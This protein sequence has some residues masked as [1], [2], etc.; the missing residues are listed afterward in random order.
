MMSL[1]HD[2]WRMMMMMMMMMVYIDDDDDD[3]DTVYM[4]THLPSCMIVSF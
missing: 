2:W 1:I 4:P 3:D